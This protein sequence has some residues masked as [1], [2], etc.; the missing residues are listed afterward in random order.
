MSWLTGSVERVVDVA[1]LR[2][3][4]RDDPQMRFDDGPQGHIGNV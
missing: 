1:E 2:M 4:D 3:R